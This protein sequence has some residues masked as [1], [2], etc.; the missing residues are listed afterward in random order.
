MT[1]VIFKNTR[2]GDV[3]SFVVGF[4][5]DRNLGETGLPGD[6]TF[7]QITFPNTEAGAGQPCVKFQSI[8][9]SS[10]CFISINGLT[11][12]DSLCLPNA[13]GGQTCTPM[14]QVGGVAVR[15]ATTTPGIDVLVGVAVDTTQ[16]NGNGYWT[17][18]PANAQI[19]MPGNVILYH[20]LVGH[21][22]HHCDGTFNASD[23]EGQA[24]AEENILRAAQGIE[25]RT[26]HEGGC[27]G[28]STGCFIAGA[29]YGSQIAPEVQLLRGIRDKVIRSTDWGES[30]FDE[31][32]RQYYAISPPIAERIASDDRLRAMVRLAVVDPWSIAVR[33]LV[34]LPADTSDPQSAVRFS[35]RAAELFSDWARTLP[36]EQARPERDVA[37]QD[38]LTIFEIFPNRQVRAAVLATLTESGFL[39]L[40]G[41]TPDAMAAIGRL[42]LPPSD[43]RLLIGG[44]SVP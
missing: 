23:P 9:A 39:P 22:L 13:S 1:V 15:V 17:R 21:A 41:A 37:I 42:G 43:L 5:S 35:E 19:S 20:E 36:L 26:A 2:E 32:Y 40:N 12:G 11:A 34:E 14:N 25:T 28:G 29:A 27:G 8:V 6:P 4:C 33:L 31:I 30:I 24:I 44:D 18:G 3:F 10:R 16:C 7:N 38:L